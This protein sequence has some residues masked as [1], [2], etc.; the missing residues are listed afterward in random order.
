M[1]N[2]ILLT[3][4]ALILARWI[5]ELW[6]DRLNRRHVLAHAIRVP[7]AFEHTIDQPT[8][9]RSVR[10]TLAKNSL[11]QVEESYSTAILLL[12]LATGILPFAL[13]ATTDAFGH[14]AWAMAAFLFAVGLGFSILGLPLAWY[15]QFRLEERFGFNTTTQRLWWIDR[16]KGLLLAVLLGY[17]LVV[18]VLKLV[19]WTGRWWWL[20]AWGS[21]L[22][23]QLLMVVLAPVVI[24]PL[25]NKFTP[26]PEGSL[27]QRLLDLGRKTAFPA[28][29]IQVMD[30]SKR[31]RHSNAFF[32]GLAGSAK[33][34]CLTPSSRS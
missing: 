13:R 18:L 2:A 14:S 23:F 20:W 26:L 24:M 31:S 16:A 9:D 3:A 6:L 7:P 11:S 1:V 33:S 27:R 22:L 28:R 8:Y 29:N 30:G 5:A 10:Y 19:E 15:E 25:F 32:T 34:S 21:L 17:P 12:A 4:A